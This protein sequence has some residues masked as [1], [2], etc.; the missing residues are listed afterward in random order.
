MTLH[1]ETYTLGDLLNDSQLGLQLLTGDDAS[2]STP[3]LGAHAIELEQPAKWLDRGWMMLTMGVRLRNKPQAQRDLIAQLQE[4]GATSLGFGVGLAFKSV[5]PALLDEA[6]RR[7]LA[8]HAS[9]FSPAG[10]DAV[11]TRLT[12]VRFRQLVE[13]RD[14]QFGAH[15][16]VAFAEGFVTREPIVRTHLLP[17][18]D[19][20]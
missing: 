6:K 20:P 11:P 5:P 8:C 4:L 3:L 14:A 19:R 2:Y 1:R 18:G 13:S 12:S 17:E 7:A 10:P 9:Q 16:G 15:A